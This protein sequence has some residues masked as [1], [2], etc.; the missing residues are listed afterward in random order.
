[1][2]SL[3]TLPS[4]AEVV[5]DLAHALHAHLHN[6]HNLRPEF[7]GSRKW[8]TAGREVIAIFEKAGKSIILARCGAL[9]EA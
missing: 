7:F 9:V 8:A 2:K 5:V 3:S 6:F 1:M 4:Q